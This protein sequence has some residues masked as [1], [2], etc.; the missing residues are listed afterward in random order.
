M[1]GFL[2]KLAVMTGY[3]V[4][5]DA[6][7]Q[8]S[9][10]V[11]NVTPAS[12]ASP[13]VQAVAHGV[14]PE[15]KLLEEILKAILGGEDGKVTRLIAACEELAPDIPDE[16]KRVKRAL[17]ILRMQAPEVLLELEKAQSNALAEEERKFKASKAAFLA[18]EVDGPKKELSEKQKRTTELESQLA[19]LAKEL[20]TTKHAA[21]TLAQKIVAEETK[22][23]DEEEK[24]LS[25]ADAAKKYIGALIQQ[26]TSLQQ[27]TK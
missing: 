9:E 16:T 4:D 10:P 18:K 2:D 27:E 1:P 13:A 19:S 6:E 5:T 21:E 11:P 25:S 7:K 22:A 17:S 15:P 23:K 12:V 20:E 8:P 14:S 26:L 24:F 3:A